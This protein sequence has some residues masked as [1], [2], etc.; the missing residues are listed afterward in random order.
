MTAAWDGRLLLLRH[1]KAVAAQARMSEAFDHSRAL[2]ER[3][4]ADAAALGARLRASTLPD[5]V[6]DLVLLSTSLRTRE[7]FD[8]LGLGD[9]PR[10]V[11][12]DS[13]YLASWASLLETLREHGGSD[14]RIMLIG[15]NPGLHDLALALAGRNPVLTQGF[16]TCTLADF[17]VAGD[18][19]DLAPSR[20]RLREVLHP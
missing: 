9:T 7:T 8:L 1:A 12:L 5:L 20:A 10:C 17:D 16:A 14:R 6:P 15:H 18:W 19:L 13:L 4:R 2:S 11:A 3:G